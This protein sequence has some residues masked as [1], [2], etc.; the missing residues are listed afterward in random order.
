MPKKLANK[1]AA[2]K[3]LLVGASGTLGRT[4][5]AELAL[6]HQVLAASRS[7][8][9]E[10]T[11]ERVLPKPVGRRSHQRSVSASG[12]RYLSECFIF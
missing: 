10:E 3:V 6:R 1:P 7:G 11:R 2:P 4:V 9:D 12:V 8:Q 5:H